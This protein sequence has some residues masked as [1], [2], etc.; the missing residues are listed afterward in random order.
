[1]LARRLGLVDTTRIERYDDAES[2]SILLGTEKARLAM[3]RDSVDGMTRRDD[4]L[5][6][7]LPDA[8]DWPAP[9]AHRDDGR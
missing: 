5:D 6:R 1:M 7:E 2:L 8:I 9:S 3:L 4:P